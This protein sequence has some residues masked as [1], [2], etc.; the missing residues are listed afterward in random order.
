MIASS[1]AGSTRRESKCSSAISRGRTTVPRIIGVD[2]VDGRENV[3]GGGKAKE[4]RT[5]RQPRR[6]AGVVSDH[7]Q[8]HRRRAPLPGWPATMPATM[9]E[10]RSRA[11]TSDRMPVRS[12]PRQH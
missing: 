4:A 6:K 3:V 2:G 5:G 7:G 1:R 11:F 12:E 9:I 8:S 10:S